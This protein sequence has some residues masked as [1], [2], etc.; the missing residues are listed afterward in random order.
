M[1]HIIV[2]IFL[3]IVWVNALVAQSFSHEAIIKGVKKDSLYKI[4]L[5]PE[6]KQFMSSD[7]HDMRIYDSNSKEVPYAVVPM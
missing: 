2:T 1:K 7:L 4:P 6:Y 3:A 5:N